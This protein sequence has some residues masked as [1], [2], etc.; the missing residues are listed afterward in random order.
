M[1]PALWARDEIYA[2]IAFTT[3]HHEEIDM[4]AIARLRDFGRKLTEN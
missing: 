4:A 1:T 2:R 3:G